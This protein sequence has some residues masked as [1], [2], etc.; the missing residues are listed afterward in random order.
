[1]NGVFHDGSFLLRHLS[2]Q[3]AEIYN[4]NSKIFHTILNSHDIE[5]L[6]CTVINDSIGSILYKQESRIFLKLIDNQ[7]KEYISFELP[8]SSELGNG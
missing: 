7:T 2:N 4:I 6:N 1:M 5:I 3:R 8:D